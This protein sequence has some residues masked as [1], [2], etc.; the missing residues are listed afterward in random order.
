MEAA[1][2]RQSYKRMMCHSLGYRIYI[3]SDIYRVLYPSRCNR[4]LYFHG[5]GNQGIEGGKAPITSNDLLWEFVLFILAALGFGG[6]GVPG[7]QK[8]HILARGHSKSATELK[9]ILA[10]GI[11][12]SLCP[13]TS[14]EK[15]ESPYW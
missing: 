6:I 3:K 9:V 8:G 2:Q 14:G 4:M 1:A 15:E 7:L 11:L 13:G 12:D 10:T 5:S